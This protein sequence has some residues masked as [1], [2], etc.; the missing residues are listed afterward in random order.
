MKIYLSLFFLILLINNSI[1]SQGCN[2]DVSI[3][4]AGVAGPFGFDQNTAGPP[5][6]YADPVGCSTG[7][8]GNDFGFGFILLQI[9]STGPLNLL[10]E[11]NSGQGFVD[12]IVYNIPAG[13][14]PCD[15]VL[16]DANEIGCN[17]AT[18]LVGCTQFGDDFPCSSSVTAPN[19]V[20]GQTIMVIA[21]D[22]STENT[23]FTLELGPT[24][25]Q[26]GA[27]NGT[28]TS[29]PGN[30]CNDAASFQLNA[31]DLGGTWTGNG[32]SSDGIFNPAIAG[33][34]AQ[35]INYEIGVAPC[36][37][38]GSTIINVIDCSV[39]TCTVNASN[40]GN[41]CIGETFDLLASNVANSISY[42]WS[43]NGF[44]SVIQNPTNIPSPLV[45]GTYTYTVLVTIAGATCTANSIITVAGIADATITSVLGDVCLD[46]PISQL[47][48]LNFGGTWIGN[49]I[50]ANGSFN[51]LI[52][53]VGIHPIT[54]SLG[55]GGCNDTEIININVIDC[56]IPTCTVL[57]SVNS[58]ICIGETFDLSASNVPNV[59]SY[60]WSG[61]GINST[62]QNVL[63]NNSPLVAGTYDYL[64]TVVTDLATCISTA[65]LVVNPLPTIFAGNDTTICEGKSITLNASG[66]ITYLW[67]N[68]VV[69]GSAF[70]P[71]QSG[72]YSVIGT[73][74]NGCV[75]GDQM[76]INLTPLETVTFTQDTTVGCSP[77]VVNFINTSPN[78]ANSEWLFNDANLIQGENITK[79]FSGSSECFSVTLITSINGCEN[80]L[81]KPDLICINLVP[82]ASFYFNETENS[83]DESSLFFQNSSLN[84]TFYEWDF[85]DSSAFS[86]ET[87]PIHT[88]FK[89][90]KDNYTITLVAKSEIGC[91]DTTK[92]DF[93]FKD[94]LI[95]YV[96]NAFTPDGNEFNTYFKPVFTSGFE[97]T[98]Y[99]LRIF[100]RWGELIFES[101]D[102]KVG[103]DGTYG[104]FIAQE[105]IY[106]WQIEFLSLVDMKTKLISGNVLL[107]K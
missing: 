106:S 75:F 29:V 92:L 39:P 28:V 89:N 94:D 9:T 34:G 1:F 49:G 93:R 74:L 21:H 33:I 48:S 59:V 72:I 11:G 23:S 5:T 82:I 103:W 45:A 13:V 42:A 44:N 97:L 53:G 70:I 47:T 17:Y 27:P 3:C 80:S 38:S 31:A 83:V 18:D 58:P 10:I 20:A 26:S 102:S 8:F 77:L 30:I 85:G 68:N 67:D 32:V 43:G 4:S 41:I 73:D 2:S 37:A 57:A 50:S 95:Y 66:G 40:S 6:D 46:D 105:G 76:Q 101:L 96:P 36:N 61:N 15:A 54:Y 25:A 22:Y 55:N 90:A 64:V 60:T 52:A 19:V 79:S 99:K 71:S 98:S 24:G 14:S 78:A 16:N 100:D 65:S 84:A 81:T 7:S 107:L 51:P 87:N 62:S 63:G 91:T 88:Y 35:T 69:N 104:S 56:N 86:N 12:V